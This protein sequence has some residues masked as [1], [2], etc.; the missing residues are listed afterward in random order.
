VTRCPKCKLEH[1]RI[2]VIRWLWLFRDTKPKPP[3]KGGLVLAML[4]ARMDAK[5][6]C[7]WTTDPDLAV[8][9]EV[10]DAA[11]VRAATRWGRD[12]LLLHRVAKGY[13]ITAERTE[14][15]LWV[16]TDPHQPTGDR[17]PHGKVPQPGT[18]SPMAAEPT[19]NLIEANRESD[20]D[21]TG[22]PSR[23]IANPEKLNQEAEPPSSPRRTTRT[24]SRGA[25]AATDDDDSEI[26][27]PDP[28]TILAGLGVDAPEAGV[29][30]GR[31]EAGGVDPAAY[32]L[33]LIAKGDGQVRGFLD[34]IR[35]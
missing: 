5:T 21:P 2:D 23:S 35:R 14:K 3:G 17:F 7:G 19:G 29:I 22:S 12:R 32:L 27:K 9:A 4:A 13:R 28:R 30:I 26:G 11:T 24:G 16:L 31:L 15:S 20:P 1:D 25:P 34:W 33:G 8:L 10:T 6:G 18:G